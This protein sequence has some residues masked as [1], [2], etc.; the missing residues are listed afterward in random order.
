VLEEV[1]LVQPDRRWLAWKH[2]TQQHGSTVEQGV[3]LRGNCEQGCEREESRAGFS[4]LSSVRIRRSSHG[5]DDDR[6]V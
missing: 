2:V 4:S 5:G 3:A 6:D 1:A